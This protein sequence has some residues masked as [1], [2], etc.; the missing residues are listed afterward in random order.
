M[1]IS[2]GA[3]QQARAVSVRTLG[4]LKEGDSNYPLCPTPKAPREQNQIYWEVF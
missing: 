3:D 2:Q 1:L 4:I